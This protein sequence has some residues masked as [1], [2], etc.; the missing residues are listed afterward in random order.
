MAQAQNVKNMDETFYKKVKVST[1]FSIFS[2]Q[3][4]IS[5]KNVRRSLK[6]GLKVS[7]K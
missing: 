7:E 2:P 1:S 5:V 4:Y 6:Q 3:L